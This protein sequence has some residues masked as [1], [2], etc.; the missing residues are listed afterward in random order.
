MLDYKNEYGE[1]R[2]KGRGFK[3]KKED[4]EELRKIETKMIQ[5]TYMVLFT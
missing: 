5:G 3:S 2:Q 1:R 4:T